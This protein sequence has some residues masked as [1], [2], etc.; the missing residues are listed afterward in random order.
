MLGLVH[1]C[2]KIWTGPVVPNTK[3]GLSLS[4]QS[5]TYGHAEI[6]ED[7]QKYKTV[8]LDLGISWTCNLC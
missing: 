3:F 2:D 7:L 5:L 6:V 4:L 1:G 8:I